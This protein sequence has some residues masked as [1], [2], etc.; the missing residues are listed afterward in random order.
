[1]LYLITG[2]LIDITYTVT[3]ISITHEISKW[4]IHNL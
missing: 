2:H 1:M 3:K 4:T